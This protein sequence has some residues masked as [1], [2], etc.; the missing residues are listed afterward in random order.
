MGKEMAKAD[1][2]DKIKTVNYKNTMFDIVVFR[3]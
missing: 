1:Y 3:L 2:Q